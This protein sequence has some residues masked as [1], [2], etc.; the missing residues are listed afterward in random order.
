MDSQYTDEDAKFQIEPIIQYKLQYVVR[1]HPLEVNLTTSNRLIV[2]QRDPTVSQ[3]HMSALSC[4]YQGSEIIRLI[5]KY[6]K[7]RKPKQSHAQTCGLQLSPWINFIQLATG[8][9]RILFLYFYILISTS[10]H[11]TAPSVAFHW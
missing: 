8:P 6:A 5:W 1:D 11:R 2:I 3:T 9:G 7:L 4:C 10:Y